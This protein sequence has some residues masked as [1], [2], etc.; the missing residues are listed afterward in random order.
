MRAVP[1]HPQ[2]DAWQGPGE[3][4]SGSWDEIKEWYA[5]Q[6]LARLEKYAPGL[7]EN[8]VQR[9][10]YSPQDLERANT[11]LTHGDSIAGS[12]H[13]D[14]FYMFRLFPGG[15]RYKTPLKDLYLVGASTWPRAGVYGTSGYLL[16]QDLLC[17]NGFFRR[18]NKK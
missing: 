1:C 13:W 10:V 5:G 6:V 2:A 7:G 15:S 12:H 17:K 18:L 9:V 14:Q 3:I 11:N 16:G 4:T 8:I